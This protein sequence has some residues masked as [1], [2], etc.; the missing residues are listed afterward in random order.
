MARVR[1]S[2]PDMLEGFPEDRPAWAEV[3]K[4]GRCFLSSLNGLGK[5]FSDPK[6]ELY[7]VKKDFSGGKT[8]FLGVVPKLSVL[9][10]VFSEGGK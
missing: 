9:K 3:G 4:R 8:S 5:C 7:G 1:R 10:K 2:L 6:S